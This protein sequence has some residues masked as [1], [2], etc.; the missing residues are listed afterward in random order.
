MNKKLINFLATVVIALLLSQFLPW[1]YVMIASFLSSLIFSLEKAAVFYIPFLAIFCF[2]TVYAFMLSSSN[3]FILAKKIAVLLP[4]RGNPY[5][6][7][8]V[9]GLIGGLAAGIAA[10]FGKQLSTLVKS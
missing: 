7:I 8:A 4:L 5:L 2:W 3:D 6:L 9:T 10:I 1:W